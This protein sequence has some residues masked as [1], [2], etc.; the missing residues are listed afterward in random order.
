MLERYNTLWTITILNRRA[1]YKNK[2]LGQL[3]SFLDPLMLMGV[4]TV[5]VILI[6]KRDEPQ[7]PVLLF[8]VILAWRWFIYTMSKAASVMQDNKGIIQTTAF[9][10]ILLPLSCILDGF[11]DYLAGLLILVPLLFV[12]KASFS[13]YM[14]WLPLL[15]TVQ[16]ILTIGLALFFTVV[17]VYLADIKNILQFSLRLLFYLSPALYTVAVIPNYLRIYYMTL[18]PFAPLFE[19]YKNV[20]VR[21]QPPSEYIGITLLMSIGLFIFG[22]KLFNKHQYGLAKAL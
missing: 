12:F 17:G 3:W 13:I 14:L 19:S 4:Y 9:P 11:L 10:K 6:F 15:L 2:I 22:Y 7:F 5:L 21:G 18:N 8:S 16:L 1:L 20:L